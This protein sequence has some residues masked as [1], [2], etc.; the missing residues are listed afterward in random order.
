VSDASPLSEY[1]KTVVLKDGLHLVL[2]PSTLADAE[3]LRALGDG[4]GP[5]RCVLALDGD[6]VAA[7]LRL[8]PEAGRGAHHV[9]LTLDP[10]YR[11]RRL[12]TWMLLDAVHLAAGLGIEQ[13]LARA[14]TDDT[15]YLAALRR[16]DFVE[17]TRAT[18]EGRGGVVVLAKRLHTAWTDF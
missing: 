14:A 2:R 9:S 1:P 16:L 10:G 17:E 12:G 4:G 13:L 11:G 8:E 5:G 6:R 15:E 3:G 7:A 18:D